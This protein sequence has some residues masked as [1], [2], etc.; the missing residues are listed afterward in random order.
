[1]NPSNGATQTIRQRR[2]GPVGLLRIT[3]TACVAPSFTAIGL[4]LFGLATGN[5]NPWFELSCGI[6][7]GLALLILVLVGL[8]ED[9]PRRAAG[10]PE[11]LRL[12][13]FWCLW[14]TPPT[15]VADYWTVHQQYEKSR[16]IGSDHSGIGSNRSPVGTCSVD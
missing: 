16:R 13:V 11:D 5:E 14:A 2:R 12:H 1:M 6:L 4:S 7:L 3:H 8:A 10:A 15:V 9:L